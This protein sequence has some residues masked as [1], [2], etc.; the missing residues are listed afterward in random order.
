MKYIRFYLFNT[1]KWILY[2][3]IL[4]SVVLFCIFQLY[5]NIN[6]HYYN[7][8]V[9]ILK[10]IGIFGNMSE[11]NMNQINNLEKSS[12]YKNINIFLELPNFNHANDEYVEDIKFSIMFGNKDN[13]L[14]MGSLFENNSS[15]MIIVSPEYFSKNG[16]SLYDKIKVNDKE[17]IIVGVSNYQVEN[18]FII[19]LDDYKNLGLSVQS[20]TIRA[21][22]TLKK[23]DIIEFV[24]Y[25]KD[26]FND[27]TLKVEHPNNDF[28]NMFDEVFFSLI[29]F[30][31]SLL[32]MYNLY[33]FTLYKK[34]KIINIFLLSGLDKKRIIFSEI[35]TIFLSF[36]IGNIISIISHKLFNVFILNSIFNINNNIM[37]LINYL[38]VFLFFVS[39]YLLSMIIVLRKNFTIFISKNIKESKI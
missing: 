29:I 32:N 37:Y 21:N 13:I 26:V 4:L 9:E 16:Y 22:D 15:G 30:I 18:S 27:N 25:I 19:S 1:I 34:I 20:Y 23:N 24:D 2:N 14:K 31:L 8:N 3:S 11:L 17:F 7:D 38:Y 12:K 28:T 33:K 5:G 36:L 6:Y 10:N 39:F 35:I